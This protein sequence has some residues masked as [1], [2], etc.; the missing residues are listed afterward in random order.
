MNEQ[1]RLLLMIL[2]Q[3]GVTYQYKCI[4]SYDVYF[5]RYKGVTFSISAHG[6]SLNMNKYLGD[7]PIDI[8]KGILC[9]GE[10]AKKKGYDI[11]LVDDN[12]EK[13]IGLN[14]ICSSH[15]DKQQL[16]FNICNFLQIICGEKF[17]K[18]KVMV[19]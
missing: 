4:G 1:K 19:V 9:L 17:L 11:V 16:F 14:I 2:N 7:Y 8:Q 6:K 15:V 18:T 5:C 10:N 12:G 3:L 13:H